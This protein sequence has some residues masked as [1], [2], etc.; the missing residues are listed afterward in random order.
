MLDNEFNVTW[1]I[2]DSNEICVKIR[3]KVLEDYYSL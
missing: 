2:S 1:L 3:Q